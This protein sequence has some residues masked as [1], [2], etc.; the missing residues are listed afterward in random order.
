MNVLYALICEEANGREDGRTDL[1]GIYHHL[2]APGFPAQ[3]ERMVLMLALEW[4]GGE[5]GRK[6][7]KIDLLDPSG[8]PVATISG[9]TD[10]SVRRAGEA[11]PQT[12]VVMPMERVIFPVAGSYRFELTVGSKKVR[13]A[14]LHLIENPDAR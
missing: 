1:T 13:L 6:N 4:D 14:P 2:Y 3:Q 8:S 10:V 9:H 12:R 5:T 11:P 7:F